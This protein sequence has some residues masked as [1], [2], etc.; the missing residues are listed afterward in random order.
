MSHI[1]GQ[2]WTKVGVLFTLH[3]DERTISMLASRPRL[4]YAF[5]HT[6]HLGA[7]I[8]SGVLA[9]VEVEDE[10]GI[11][12]SRT[13]SAAFGDVKALHRR[14]RKA[15]NVYR[16]EGGGQTMFKHLITLDEIFQY[17]LGSAPTM[18]YTSLEMLR[19]ME[20]GAMRSEPAELFHEHAH[21]ARQTIENVQQSFALLG[22]EAH[23]APPPATRGLDKEFKSFMAKTD[24]TLMDAIVLEGALETEHY[25]TA[26]YEVLIFQTKAR[27]AAG[28][29]ELLIQSLM[30]EKAAMERVMVASDA[31][32]RADATSQEDL[33]TA[34]AP[35]VKARPSAS[36][37]YLV[38]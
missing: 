30:L 24:N 38:S 9:T 32:Y 28:I 7:W 12:E 21:E 23:Q 36:G 10:A 5:G 2:M 20:K 34:P 11:V 16:R 25:G 22:A 31:I 14:D 6:E 1:R 13:L 26:V 19:D 37:M 33:G 29:P 4:V 17:K 8:F 3:D 15:H 27:G 18:E 35:A